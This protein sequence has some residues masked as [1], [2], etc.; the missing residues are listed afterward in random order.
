MLSCFT[1]FPA[2]HKDNWLD[3]DKETLWY[4]QNIDMVFLM[5]QKPYPYC[6]FAG[7]IHFSSS[8]FRLLFQ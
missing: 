4:Q 8:C 5:I 3:N 7:Y 6:V 2:V 1:A